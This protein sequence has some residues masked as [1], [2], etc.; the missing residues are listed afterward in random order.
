MLGVGID[1]E[2]AEADTEADTEAEGLEEEAVVMGEGTQGTESKPA[3]ASPE[4]AD[5]GCV[6][7]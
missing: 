4:A 3:G 2:A 7:V 6:G 1:P 5:W